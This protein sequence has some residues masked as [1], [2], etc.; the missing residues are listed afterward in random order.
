MRASKLAIFGIVF[1]A[2]VIGAN[3]L[4]AAGDPEVVLGGPD[5]PPYY[6]MTDGALHGNLADILTLLWERAGYRTRGE[7]L[8][9]ARLMANI[10]NGGVHSSLLV[11]NGVLDGAESVIR[12]PS[13]I[14]ELVLNLYS[15]KAPVTL[16][17]KDDL[18]GRSIAV[19]LG[20]GYGGLREWMKRPEN[21]ITL[22]DVVAPVVA[23]RLLSAGIEPYALLYDVNFRDAVKHLGTEAPGVIANPFQRVPA[24]VY[25]G[26]D[27]PGGGQRAMDALMTAY[28]ALLAEGVLERPDAR[29]EE[30]IKA[31]KVN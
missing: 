1:L 27:A 8:P 13:P 7:I 5:F 24:Y 20:Y 26:R 11:R 16:T 15:M 28:A 3:P 21:A 18:K 25:V 30:V 12:S 10:V 19:V 6:Q 4:V 2:G 23:V 29:P 22:H 17:S 14:T 31:P 9:P